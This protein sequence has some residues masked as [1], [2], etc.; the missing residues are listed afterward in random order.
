MKLN[1]R[2]FLATLGTLT[3]VASVLPSAM[4]HDGPEHKQPGTIN[5]LVEIE[6]EV[7]QRLRPLK[8]VAEPVAESVK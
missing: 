8:S 3:S 6:P 7:P 5:Q 2:L 4:A 1:K